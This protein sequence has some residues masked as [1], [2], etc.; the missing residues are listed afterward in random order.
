MRSRIIIDYSQSDASIFTR[1]FELAI[2]HEGDGLRL[3]RCWEGLAFIPSITPKLPSWCPDLAN[4]SHV[5][6]GYGRPWKKLSDR[7]QTIYKLFANVRVS[8]S[9]NSLH[10]RIMEADTVAQ[11]VETSCPSIGP[12]PGPATKVVWTGRSNSQDI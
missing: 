1:A 5:S 4:E 12:H 3:P 9:E 10:L 8:P 11:V 7:V 2:N 6:I